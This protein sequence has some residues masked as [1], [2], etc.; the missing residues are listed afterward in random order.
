MGFPGL[1][2]KLAIDSSAQ[3]RITLSGKQARYSLLFIYFD[4]ATK[5]KKI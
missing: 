5:G 3:I 2:G 1:G 4:R